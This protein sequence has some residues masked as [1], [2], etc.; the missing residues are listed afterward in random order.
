MNDLDFKDGKSY[1]NSEAISEEDINGNGIKEAIKK[2]LTEGEGR[3]PLAINI[4]AKEESKWCSGL[5]DGQGH[6]IKNLYINRPY[7]MGI[8][9]FSGNRGR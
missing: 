8:G 1:K 9:L 2:E 4:S 5:L 6:K 7:G 3:N